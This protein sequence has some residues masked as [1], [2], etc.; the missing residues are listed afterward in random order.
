MLI[1]SP[2]ILGETIQFDDCIFF[3]RGFGSTT[4]ERRCFRYPKQKS[5]MWT[6]KANQLKAFYLDLLVTYNG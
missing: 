5:I 6:T 4:N 3:K 2:P 1:F